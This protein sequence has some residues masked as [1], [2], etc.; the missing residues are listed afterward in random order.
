LLA[1][2]A[3]VATEVSMGVECIL[4]VASDFMVEVIAVAIVTSIEVA[5]MAMATVTTD[6]MAIIL[7]MVT[8][9]L[10]LEPQLASVF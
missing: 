5:A 8:T 7:I 6:I 1:L 2:V 3:V 10:I 4:D 9:V